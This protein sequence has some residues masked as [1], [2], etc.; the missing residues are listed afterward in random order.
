MQ[1]DDNKQSSQRQKENDKKKALGNGA[2]SNASTSVEHVA[3]PNDQ[4][5]RL[6]GDGQDDN[7]DNEAYTHTG[8]IMRAISDHYYHDAPSHTVQNREQSYENGGHSATQK[9]RDRKIELKT[10]LQKER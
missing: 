5:R 3:A 1:L 9:D 6:V 8:S 2:A 10:K 4:R 7:D